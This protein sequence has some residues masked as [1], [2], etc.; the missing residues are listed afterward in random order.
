[1]TTGHRHPVRWWQRT[2]LLL[3]LL[4]VFV[5]A[6]A[7]GVYW[8]LR[9][10][11]RIVD[12]ML[13]AIRARG[14]PV[15]LNELEA[16]Y[17]HAPPDVD[18]TEFW[19]TAIDS[20][21]GP[22]F[23]AAA[24][25]LPIVGD[26]DHDIPLAGNPWPE[27]EAAEQ[28]LRQFEPALGQLHEAAARG[29]RVRYPVKLHDGMLALMP[30]IERLR[31]AARLLMLEAEVAAHCGN[32]E[33]AAR[34]L[35]TCQAMADTLRHEPTFV[36]ALVRIA[37]HGQVILRLERL[38]PVV[39]FSDADRT[40][41]QENLR[42][43]RLLDNVRL[44]LVG[45]RAVGISIFTEPEQFPVGVEVNRL[46]WMLARANSEDF[47]LYLT[48]MSQVIDVSSQPWPTLLETARL[49]D[50]TVDQASSQAPLLRRRHLIT[51]LIYSAVAVMMRTFAEREAS[52]RAAD[53]GIAVD[54]YRRQCGRLP[55]TLAVLV[56]DYLPAVPLDPFDG[57]TLR[58]AVRTAEQDVVEV[59]VYSVGPNRTDDGGASGDDTTN[60]ADVTVTLRYAGLQP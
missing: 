4:L 3:L 26:A 12:E 52:A 17:E 6:A 13:A 9:G 35:H 54:R 25:G 2:L 23:T 7:S 8:Y 31:G 20:L 59:V 38:V 27:L 57:Q 40:R 39:D 47:R 16:W 41:L 22:E 28:L 36:S 44:A 58:Y 24:E 1:M 11:Q 30:H 14:E 34:A 50:E 49:A 60:Q 10:Q 29:G 15:T 37:T 51:Q 45:E 42:N 43:L 18:G 5:A 46:A 48:Q 33:Q 56:P 55:E 32:S 53:V 21:A 19:L